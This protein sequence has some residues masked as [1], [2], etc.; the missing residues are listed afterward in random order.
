VNPRFMSMELFHRNMAFTLYHADMMPLMAMGETSVER[1]EGDVYR[2]R[3]DITNERLI[4]TITAR[5]EEN[6]VVRPDL[7][8]V[9]GDLEVIAA[10]WVPSKHRPGPTQLIDQAELDRI[11]V[12]SG[13]PGRTTR[14]LEYLV[15]GTGDMTIT[16]DAVKGGHRAGP[17]AHRHGS[18]PATERV[19]GGCRVPATLP[20]RPP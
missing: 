13:H 20:P 14:T 18:P 3:V 17:V 12:R 7:V 19:P 8:T 1:V 6:H 11:L 9:D 16:Y 2:V 15:R 4:P 10:G 5:A